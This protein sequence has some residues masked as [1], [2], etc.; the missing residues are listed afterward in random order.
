[1]R[2]FFGMPSI[3]LT[4]SPD[5]IHGVLN[6][7]LSIGQE[8]NEQFPAIAEGFRD[9]IQKGDATFCSI[10]VA[11]QELRA[12]LAKGPVAAAETFRLM[13]E[14]V[15]SILLGTPPD[16]C[17]KRTIPLPARKPGIFTFVKKTAF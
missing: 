8:S 1:M 15:F 11:P 16:H 17:S 7:R 2:Y 13:T 3:F 4:Y 6:L 12:L 10:P 5:D 14:A 9:A